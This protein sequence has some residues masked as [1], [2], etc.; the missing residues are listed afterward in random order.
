MSKTKYLELVPTGSNPSW[1]I[2]IGESDPM[3]VSLNVLSIVS[4]LLL[5]LA[6]NLLSTEVLTST[7]VPTIAPLSKRSPVGKLPEIIETVVGPNTAPCM[8]NSDSVAAE[9]SVG[10]VNSKIAVVELKLTTYVFTGIFS[11]VTS[12]PG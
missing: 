8:Y 6:T 1:V 2:H 12:Q 7:G 10:L 11:P 3:T 5:N 4:L 9:L